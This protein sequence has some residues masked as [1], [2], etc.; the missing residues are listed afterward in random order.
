MRT[1]LHTTYTPFEHLC[2]FSSHICTRVVICP[3]DCTRGKTYVHNIVQD[4]SYTSLTYT[5]ISLVKISPEHT[6]QIRQIV[7]TRFAA[8]SFTSGPTGLQM[9]HLLSSVLT[10][11]PNLCKRNRMQCALQYYTVKACAQRN[12]APRIGQHLV[13]QLSTYR[14]TS[15]PYCCAITARKAGR[16]ENPALRAAVCAPGDQ[17]RSN[18]R[19]SGRIPSGRD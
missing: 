3:C 1:L 5:R 13:L 2:G 12:L 10:S 14:P 9:P 7:R 16:R 8:S 19:Y 6:R 18:A 11:G 15:V 4:R 17:G